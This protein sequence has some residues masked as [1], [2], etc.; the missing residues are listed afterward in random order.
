MT[1]AYKK[2]IE[3]SR[4]DYFTLHPG[5]ISIA[6]FGAIDLRSDELKVT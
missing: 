6:L 1:I 4:L 5:L 3:K 2:N